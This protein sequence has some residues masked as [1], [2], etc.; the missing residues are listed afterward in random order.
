MGGKVVS[1]GEEGVK[2]RSEEIWIMKVQKKGPFHLR[3][4]LFKYSWG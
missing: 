3:K 2:L 4:D 1:A